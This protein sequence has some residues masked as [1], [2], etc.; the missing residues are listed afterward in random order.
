MGMKRLLLSPFMDIKPINDRLDLVEV[1]INDTLVLEG[2][3]DLL[4]GICDLER[5]ISRINYSTATNARHLLQLG[6]GLQRVPALRD[7]LGKVDRPLASNL[8]SR[9][10]DFDP[11][12]TRILATI[13]DEPPVR[14]TEGCMI[15]DGVNAELDELRGIRANSQQWLEKFQETMRQKYGLTTLRV[16]SN[17]VFGYFIE[18]SKNYVDKV[19]DTWTRKQTLV[20]A[21]R[22]IN[23]ELKEMEEKILSAEGKIYDIEKSIFTEL[24]AAIVA[25]TGDIQATAK[26]IAEIDAFVTFASV[27]ASS[28]FV[29]P[30]LDESGAIH[31]KGGRHP[32][33]E[34]LI[35]TDKFITNDLDID[36]ATNVLTIVTGPNMSGKSTFLRQVCLIAIMAQAGCFVPASSASIGVLDKIF[37]RVGAQDDISRQRSTFLLEMNETAYILNHATSRS[38]VILDELGRG[39]STFDGVSLAWAVAEYLQA[40]RVKTMFATHYHQLSDLES[41]LPR[42]KNLNVLVKE[43]ERTK[44]LVFLH[45]V[46]EGSCDRSYGIQVAKLAGVPLP[47]I[48]RA[49]EILKKLTE[50][51]PLTTDRI[52]LIGEKGIQ[53]PGLQKSRTRQTILMP[54]V[55]KPAVNP[56]YE[57]VEAELARLNPDAITPIEALN[58]LK[59]LK[60]LMKE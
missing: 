37:S 5:L 15:R 51:D 16:K 41:F 18:I 31:I 6:K 32:T 42:T 30:V 19:P 36:P 58:I 47:V 48:N 8:S 20:N 38:L 1:F 57:K 39:T 46:V 12:V 17:D 53:S 56:K 9:L 34:K 43:D 4:S 26:A 28:R 52:K 29:R 25:L 3:R 23:P 50:D 60:D 59:C 45:K 21:E 11:I 13:V 10:A 7:I 55:Q 35:G 24:K 22:Y 33:I 27:S 40:K 54:I 49:Q 2:L 44:D 14:V